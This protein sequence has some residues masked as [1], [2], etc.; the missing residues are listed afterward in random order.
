VG[1]FELALSFRGQGNAGMKYRS[2]PIPQGN[3]T[4]YY[5]PFSKKKAGSIL[6]TGRY[7]SVRELVGTD[8]STA[9]RASGEWNEY[10]IVARG[11]IITHEINGSMVAKASDDDPL[12]RPSGLMAFELN[13]G[14][15]QPAYRLSFKNIRLKKLE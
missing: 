14:P 2:K 1:D 5:A 3:L 13:G 9:L 6:Y 10:R 7:S 4:G 12:Y 8:A 11:R 15:K